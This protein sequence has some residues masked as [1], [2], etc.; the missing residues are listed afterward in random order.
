M[1]VW[2]NGLVKHRMNLPEQQ[3]AVI[4]SALLLPE[5]TP[6]VLFVFF[7]SLVCLSTASS[8]TLPPQC[9]CLCLHQRDELWSVYMDSAE[10]CVWHIKDNTKPSHRVALQDCTGCHCMIKVKNQVNMHTYKLPC[11][12][13]RVVS[14][15]YGL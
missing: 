7:F 15:L 10:V 1:E 9:V 14:L 13:V 2:R 5:V 6:K 3:R 4:S 8:L 12:A 11:A